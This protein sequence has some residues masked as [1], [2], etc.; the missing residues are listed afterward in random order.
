[1]INKILIRV[2]AIIIGAVCLCSCS[3]KPESE[4]N[5]SEKIQSSAPSNDKSYPQSATR[6][7]NSQHYQSSGQAN[8]TT[9]SE[10]FQ[11]AFNTGRELGYSDAINGINDC[12]AAASAYSDE[13]IKQAFIQGYELGQAEA[14]ANSTSYSIVY[15]EVDYEDDD[16]YEDGY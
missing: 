11:F 7:D 8:T 15:D 4:N 16:Y 5:T 6:P 2:V 14:G 1:M 10:A 3:S 13:W 9:R 12:N